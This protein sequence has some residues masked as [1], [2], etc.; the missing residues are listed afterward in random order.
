MYAVWTP[1]PC[2]ALK[3]G[4]ASLVGTIRGVVGQLPA[5]EGMYAVIRL[6]WSILL[7]CCDLLGA[8]I[9]GGSYLVSVK[10][11]PY[12]SPLFLTLVLAMW[13]KDML[14]RPF[15]V[16]GLYLVRLFKRCRGNTEDVLEATFH[17]S[18]RLAWDWNQPA[19]D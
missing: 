10:S 19:G 3:A 2:L 18:V 14:C 5:V 9:I 6:L 17:D 16:A 15:I 1:D 13:G 4:D 8:F 12:G 7:F 11:F